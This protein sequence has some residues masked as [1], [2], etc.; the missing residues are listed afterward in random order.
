MRL[1]AWSLTASAAGL[2]RYPYRAKG[3]C[4]LPFIRLR[5]SC[6]DSDHSQ[7]SVFPSLHPSFHDLVDRYDAFILDQFAVLH[8]GVSALPGAIECVDYLVSRGKSLILLSNTSAPAEAA[9]KRLLQLGFA[10]GAFVG[11]VTS[12]EEASRYIRE[13]HGSSSS[14]T[15][16]LFFT[17]DA[18]LPNNPRLTALPQTFLEQ[19]GQVAVA[20]SVQDAD[21]LV[22]HGSEVWYRGVDLPSIPLGTFVATGDLTNVVDDLLRQCLGQNLS[23]VCANPDLVVQTPTGGMAYMPGR[24][25]QRYAELAANRDDVSCRVFGKPNPEH[26]HACVR[27]LQR[28]QQEA[29]LEQPPLR[30]AHVGDSLHHDIHGA[31]QAGIASIFVTSGIHQSEVA[32]TF[33]ELPSQERLQQLFQTQGG[34]TPTHVVPAFRL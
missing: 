6:G 31:N 15:R 26:F 2:H 32:T 13:T 18:S 23:A 25:A 9:M 7:Q 14:P 24:L 17:W 34:V 19:C 22:F 28:Q 11:A 5:S 30:I 27:Q 8:N 21:L 20:S 4:R 29:S 10:P 1:L 12:G 33:G 3:L 16:I